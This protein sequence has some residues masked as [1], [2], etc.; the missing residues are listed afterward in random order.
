MFIIFS[1]DTNPFGDSNL[2]Q[3]FIWGKKYEKDKRE[4]VVS[5]DPEEARLKLIQD[6]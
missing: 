5:E 2:L 3:P 4:G 6:I 1:N